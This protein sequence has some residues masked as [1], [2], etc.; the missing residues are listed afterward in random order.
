MTKKPAEDFEYLSNDPNFVPNPE[1]EEF[2]EEEISRAPKDP[3]LLANHKVTT[4]FPALAKAAD[5]ASGL[6]EAY[7]EMEE[8]RGYQTGA[9]Q[10]WVVAHPVKSKEGKALGIFMTGWSF[11]RYAAYLQEQAKRD[12]SEAAEK[13]KK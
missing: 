1:I 3:D 11:R 5:P 4:A 10:E 2:M 8:M 7:G 13:E 12:L 6:V 9:D